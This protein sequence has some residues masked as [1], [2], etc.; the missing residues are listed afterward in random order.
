MHTEHL[1]EASA[2][3]QVIPWFEAPS[4]HFRADAACNLDKDRVPPVGVIGEVQFPRTHG[5]GLSHFYNLDLFC[6]PVPL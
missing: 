1:R 2:T 4:L 3:R 6:V 5:T